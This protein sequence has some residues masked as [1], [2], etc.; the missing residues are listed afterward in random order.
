VVAYRREPQVSPDSSTETFV[1]LRLEIDNWR[2]QGVRF[3]LRTGKRLPQRMT[4][5]E[6]TFRHPPVSIFHPFE[7]GDPHPNVLKM[8]I[9]PDEGFELSF[10]VKAPGQG[11]SLQTQRMHF[12]YAEAF[13]PLPDAYRTLLLDILVG[14]QTLFVHAD[15]VESSWGLY[16]PL[17]DS[18]HS[19]YRYPAGSWGPAEAD[20]LLSE[21]DGTWKSQMSAK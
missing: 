15:E 20:N 9:Q 8:M 19:L 11:I 13:G 3:Y 1:A 12:R 17:L 7:A 6:V 10:Q 4:Q 5:I 21:L 14:D 18:L 16:G 2:W